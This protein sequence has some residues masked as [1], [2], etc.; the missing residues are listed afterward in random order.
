MTDIG[1]GDGEIREAPN[2]EELR[3]ILAEARTIALIGASPKP[4]R[5]SHMVM[6]Y[7]QGAGYRVL[8]VNPGQEGREILGEKVHGSLSQIDEHIDIVDIFRRSA[9]APPVVDEAIKAG[10]GAVWMQLGISN[11]EAARKAINAGLTVV[12]NRCTKIEHARLLG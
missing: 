1:G 5:P 4:E 8:P 7:L 3:R 6:A 2:D 12:M 11:E 9:Q 10:A